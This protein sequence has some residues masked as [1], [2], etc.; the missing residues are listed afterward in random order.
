[1]FQ[2]TSQW[3]CLRRNSENFM[4]TIRYESKKSEKDAVVDC[5]SLQATE[6]H[7]CGFKERNYLGS[8][9]CKSNDVEFNKIGRIV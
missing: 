4:F 5:N 1:M 3:W 9:K 6:K 2:A 7:L 8:K